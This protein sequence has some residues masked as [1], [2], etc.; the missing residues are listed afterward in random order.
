MTTARFEKL[1]HAYGNARDVPSLLR[2]LGA[3]EAKTRARALSRL[4]ASICHQ[5]T[6]YSATPETVPLLV[7]LLKTP[8]TKGRD[9]VL[10]LLADIATLD[11]PERF[12]LTGFD[13]RTEFASLPRLWIRSVDA[14]NA[15]AG[16]Y[17]EL[18]G[19]NEAPVRAQTA[20][21]LAWLDREA[22]RSLPA[23]EHALAEEKNAVT[24]ATLLL[25]L[26]FLLRAS[27]SPETSALEAVLTKE[28]N[29]VV[30][31]AAALALTHVRLGE[32]GSNEVQALALAAMSRPLAKTGLPWAGGNLSL[33]ALRALAGVRDAHATTEPL[34][35][36][37]EG[38]TTG[39][40]FVANVLVRRLFSGARAKRK[41]PKP[42]HAK[43]EVVR[44]DLEDEAALSRLSVTLDSLTP[45]QRRLLDAI[46]AGVA[47]FDDELMAALAQRGLPSTSA[48]LRRW[49]AGE[50]KRESI[51]D[52]RIG[53]DSVAKRIAAASKARGEARARLVQS[54]VKAL[55]AND[56]IDAAYAAIVELEGDEVLPVALDLA[57][58]A[59]PKAEKALTAAMARLER[60]GA[61]QREHRGGLVHFIGCYVLV[62]VG[63]AAL[64]L[65]KQRPPDPRVDDYLQRQYSFRP[66]VRDALAALPTQRREKWVLASQRDNQPQPA[67]YFQGAWPYWVATPTPAVTKRVLK[68]VST[69][70]PKDRWGG[71]RQK[72]AEPH[73]VAYIEALRAAKQD[74]TPCERAL[75]KLRTRAK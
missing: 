13:S 36:A 1:S 40:G 53:S 66:Q 32:V 19:A 28:R 38:G 4:G 61:P 34:L 67:Q 71:A 2:S 6:F 16:V 47:N 30:R 5:G 64:A 50:L 11:E 73:L 31:T 60:A 26:G 9:G 27:K 15:G 72:Y 54:L 56:V 7:A 41:G 24:R 52:R 65:A 44:H 23:V 69:W 46:A 3:A 20:F 49:L 35:A 51:L 18:L 25:S 21:L 68:H 17:R 75:E 39:G 62:G 43:G 70:Q 37:L 74:A 8:T 58:A 63:L 33:F 29:A 48:L 42:K 10:R 14:V 45:Q 59:G 12:L 55:P 22:T 57:W